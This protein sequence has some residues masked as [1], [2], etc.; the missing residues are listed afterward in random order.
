MAA[1]SKNPVSRKVGVAFAATHWSAVIE[2]GRPGSPRAEAALGELY[3]TYWYPLYA[4]IRAR[5]HSPHDAQDLV[6]EFFCVLLRK[7]YLE[8]VSREKGRFRSYLIGALKHFLANAWHK[9]RREKRG[10]SQ[11]F[12]ALDEVMAE[13]RFGAEPRDE[14]TPERL[15]E[16][17]WA[18]LLLER[19]LGQLRAEHEGSGRIRHFGELKIFLSGE[20]SERSYAEIG[21]R[22]AMSEAA[23]K[24]AV[25]RLRQRYRELL[26][27]EIAHTL[28]NPG[29]IEDELRHLVRVLRG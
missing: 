7:N 2:A 10:G 11:T 13:K 18:A 26:R 28:A 15:Y 1:T 9:S 23:V 29:D 21:A 27:R 4:Y 5:G 16:R 24:V 17:S 12:I 19:V 8:A 3:Q 25:H 20:K 6:Q 14:A 22:L